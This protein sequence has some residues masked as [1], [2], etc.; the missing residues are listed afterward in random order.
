M[1][2]DPT[3][4][5]PAAPPRRFRWAWALVTVP[6]AGMSALLL[7]SART[8]DG[9]LAALTGIGLASVPWWAPRSR[10]FAAAV[11]ALLA[12]A[13]VL[14]SPDGTQPPGSTTRTVFLAGSAPWRLSP[15][16]LVPEVDQLSLATHLVWLVD[17]ML[18]RRGAARLRTAIRDVYL[19]GERDPSFRA[20]GSAMNESLFDEDRGRIDVH[21]PPHAPGERLPGVVFL[22][23]SAGSWKGYFRLWS[24]LADRERFVV[25]QPS[26]GFGD[27]QRPGGLAAIERAH[28]YLVERTPSDPNR[29]VLACL[30]NGGRGVT[31]TLV[32]GVEG[33]R[34]V[35]FV[36]AVIEPRVLE[37]PSWEARWR[38]RPMLVIHGA[39]DDR[40]PTDYL[41]EGVGMLREAGVD[42]T[43]RIVAN[44]DHF[45]IFTRP[46]LVFDE[47]ARWM[48]RVL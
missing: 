36:S 30:S 11:T 3:L 13:L 7:V 23:G 28:R 5:E 14:R 33:Y 45:L 43:E 18:D 25:V 15:T 1:T 40:I 17:L 8:V 29:V 46:A 6:L 19:P 42:V 20:M 10:R 37:N 9:A 12:V 21:V 2:D 22:H 48:R 39:N 24:Q 44:E 16:N 4:D 32:A 41:D 31:R 34:G 35:V 27:W 38:G 47:I 26:F